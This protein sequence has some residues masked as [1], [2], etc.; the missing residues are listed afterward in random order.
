MLQSLT[1]EP[2]TA[3]KFAV[4]QTVAAGSEIP[5]LFFVAVFVACNQEESQTAVSQTMLVNNE[6]RMTQIAHARL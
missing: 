5:S 3:Q 6:L 1:C 2:V 4:L